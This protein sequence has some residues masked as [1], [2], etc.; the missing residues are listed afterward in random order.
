M[1]GQKHMVEVIKPQMEIDESLDLQE[2]GWVIQRIGWVLLYAFLIIAAL[3]L[4]GEGVLSK[5]SIN[6]SAASIEYEKFFR[7]E[8]RMEI[9]VDVSRSTGNQTIVAFPNNYLKHFQIVSI[10]PEPKENRVQ[11]NKV[12]YIFEGTAPMNIVFYLVPKQ[13]GQISGELTVNNDT[14]NLSHFIYP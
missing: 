1:A 8:G 12:N 4:F 7:Y 14:F 6:E 3:G 9:K 5:K 11:G 2:R 13:V 10:L